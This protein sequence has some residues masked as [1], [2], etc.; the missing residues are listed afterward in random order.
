MNNVTKGALTGAITTV[1]LSIAPQF[2]RWCGPRWEG[3]PGGPPGYIC[4]GDLFIS[5]W[6]ALPAGVV[7][8]AVAGATIAWIWLGQSTRN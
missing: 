4:I 6:I 5:P 1:A 8:V 7:L 2:F 3:G